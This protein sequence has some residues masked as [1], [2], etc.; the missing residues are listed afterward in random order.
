MLLN[1]VSAT[2]IVFA[3]KLVLSVYK[4]HF[5]YALTLIHTATTMVGLLVLQSL[6]V[7]CRSAEWHASHIL[8]HLRS[9]TH[10]CMLTSSSAW[11]ST[12]P[13]SA[14][15]PRRLECGH[16]H[17]WGCFRASDCRQCRCVASILLVSQAKALR[18]HPFLAQS[19]QS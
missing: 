6:P 11:R 18:N 4:F 2:C 16:S 5:V 7:L 1:I 12:V 17:I 9:H 14:V 13:Q 3:N 19:Q 10:S 8:L 15:F